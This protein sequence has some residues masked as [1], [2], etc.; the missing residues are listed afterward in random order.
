[1]GRI[2]RRLRTHDRDE[3]KTWHRYRCLV[4]NDRRRAGQ[5]E[6]RELQKF[7]DRHG[8]LPRLNQQ[9]G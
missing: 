1:M 4:T 3:A 9:L 2:E 5:I 8:R 6:R 7:R